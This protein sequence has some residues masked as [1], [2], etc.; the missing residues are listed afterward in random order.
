MAV[1]MLQISRPEKAIQI[2]QTRGRKLS[3]KRR[4]ESSK[5]RLSYQIKCLQNQHS[6]YIQ[7]NFIITDSSAIF[8]EYS[9]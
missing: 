6:E 4:Q 3:T 5:P 8:P 9:S 2:T 7:R 1:S